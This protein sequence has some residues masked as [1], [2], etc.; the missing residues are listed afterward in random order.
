M[1]RK[2]NGA[3]KTSHVTFLYCPLITSCVFFLSYMSPACFIIILFVWK[4]S[5]ISFGIETRA[6]GKVP[7]SNNICDEQTKKIIKKTPHN[8]R[9]EHTEEYVEAE[10]KC[11]IRI[12]SMYEYLTIF[13]QNHLLRK[14][15][16]LIITV[17]E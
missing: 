2:E 16:C 1:D 4:P 15:F 7:S 6:I 9:Y 3:R 8:G 17:R 13:L 10:G 11:F 5:L 12:R 14:F